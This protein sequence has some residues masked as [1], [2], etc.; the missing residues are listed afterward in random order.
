[1]KRILT[2]LA[3]ICLAL[4]PLGAADVAWAVEPAGHSFCQ[5]GMPGGRDELVRRVERSLAID[6]TGNRTV[7]G[8]HAAPIHWLIAFQSDEGDPK[9]HLTSVSELPAYLRKLV[10][11]DVPRNIE[12]KTSCLR[13]RPNHVLA[14]EMGCLQR[15][16]RP[17]EVIY[18]NPDT[19]QP[20]LWGSCINPG[21][22]PPLDVVV[23]GQRCLEVKFDSVQQGVPVRFGYIDSVPLSGRCH[24]YQLAGVAERLYETPEECPDVYERVVGDRHFTVVCSWESVEVNSSRIL[25]RPVQVQNVS[26]SFVT[27]ANGTN[28]WFLP[29]EAI[30]GLATICWELPDG[31]FR[32]VSVGRANYVNGVATITADD[33]RGAV[34]RQ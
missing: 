26:G 1:M 12:A 6:P 18:G 21:F 11:M 32:T 24:A 33:V 10:V 30:N 13:D 29:P 3:A 28:S 8:C 15:T 25:G 7:E 23:T 2:G 20:V 9:A 34:Y 5:G 4:P 14:V 16:P 27:R 17:G 22:A 31:T 19:G